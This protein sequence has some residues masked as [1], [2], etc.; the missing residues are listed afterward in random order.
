MVSRHTTY[1]MPSP[2]PTPSSPTPA[3]DPT[4]AAAAS[5]PALLTPLEFTTGKEGGTNIIWLCFR[6]CKEKQRGERSYWKCTEAPREC[7]AEMSDF[8]DYMEY[9]WLGTSARPPL[10]SQ[11]S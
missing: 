6:Y 1:H 3:A 9:T 10:F 2:D 5:P 8:A 11:I 4:P 7:P